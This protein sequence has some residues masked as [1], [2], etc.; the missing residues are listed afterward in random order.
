MSESETELYQFQLEQVE[1]ALSSDPTNEELLK[2]QHDLKDLI[3]LTTQYEQVAGSAPPSSTDNTTN[4]RK[5]SRSPNLSPHTSENTT[6]RPSTSALVTHQFTVGQEVKAKWSQDGQYYR[7]TITAIGGADQ[8]FSVQ[9]R[10]YKDIEVVSVADIEPLEKD[11][12]KGIFEGIKKND[13]TD[14]GL[15]ATGS[16][17]VGDDGNKKKKDGKKVKKVSEV[18]VKKNA[19]LNFA[20]GSDKKKKKQKVAPIN[21]KSIFKTPDNPESKVG[22][23]GS[24]RGM[25][26]YQQ[27]GKHSF[28]NSSGEE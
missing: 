1:H 17:S 4:S 24:G 8:I 10:G 18:E 19:W 15:L 26:S 6:N 14:T 12:R 25:T 3:A 5:R 20:K 13:D 22:V 16:P 2:L 23:V 7:A 9:F 27:R 21:K 28:T 11:K